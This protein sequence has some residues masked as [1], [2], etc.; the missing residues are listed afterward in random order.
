MTYKMLSKKEK[1]NQNKE[2][3]AQQ[4]RATCREHDDIERKY[5]HFLSIN[6]LYCSDDR[7]EKEK[8]R[9]IDVAKRSTHERDKTTETK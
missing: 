6:Y 9:D 4:T 7:R 5:S 2:N 1:L 8:D 3:I